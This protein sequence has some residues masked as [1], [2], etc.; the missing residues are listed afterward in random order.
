[1]QPPSGQGCGRYT[2]LLLAVLLVFGLCLPACGDNPA[3]TAM[4][5]SKKA[6]DLVAQERYMEAIDLYNEAIAIDPYSSTIWNR[7]GKAEMNV[8][9]YPDAVVAF[10]KALDLDPYHSGAWKNKGD[11]LHAQGEYQAAIDAYDRALAIN[12]NDLN[13]LLQKGINLQ[14]LG[15]PD[16]AMVVYSEVVRIAEREVRRNPNEARYDATLWTNKGDALARLGRFPEA[17]Q[18]YQAAVTINPKYERAITGMES[19]NET[20][21]RARGSPELLN[22]PIQPLETPTGELPIP[23]SPFSVTMALCIMVLAS[24]YV[25][26]GRWK[27]V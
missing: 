16:Q 27:S 6:D 7:L 20:L 10:Q 5:L 13:A 23:L 2:G 17:L 3:E 22:T 12:A 26:R 25:F 1:M 11:A 8:G 19:V 24:C 4:A 15:K 18:A 14:L 9:R 21:Y